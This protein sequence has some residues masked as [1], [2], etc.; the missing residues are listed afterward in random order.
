MQL[1]Q[2]F[3]RKALPNKSRR[4]MASHSAELVGL[5]GGQ[6]KSVIE[7][8]AAVCYCVLRKQLHHLDGYCEDCPLKQ[9]P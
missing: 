6:H 2:T 3:S 8:P 9:L 5:V 4:V 7:K 1:H